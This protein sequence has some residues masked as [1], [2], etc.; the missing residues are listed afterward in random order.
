[1]K[2][3]APK[4]WDLGELKDIANITMGQPPPGE[5]YNGVG[6]GVIFYQRCTDF[7]SRFPT[8]RHCTTEPTRF[9]KQGDILLSVRATVGSMNISISVCCI[10]RGL[11]ALNSKDNCTPFFLKYFEISSKYLTDE[12]Q[13]EQLLVQS[14]K[15]IY[16]HSKL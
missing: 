16:F 13:M 14:L 6:H 4:D 9:A 11:A 3:E 5:S 7:G 10:G 15:M 1:M 2:R 12:I 8:V